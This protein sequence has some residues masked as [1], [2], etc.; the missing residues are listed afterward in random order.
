[1]TCCRGYRSLWEALRPPRCEWPW[2]RTRCSRLVAHRRTSHELRRYAVP[3]KPRPT[4]MFRAGTGSI[5]QASSANV[6][7]T[8]R[9]N[10]PEKS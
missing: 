5:S 8:S 10:A 6:H 3:S 7:W 4:V 9:S 2:P 1:M